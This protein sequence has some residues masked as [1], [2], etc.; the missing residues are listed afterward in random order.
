[1]Q[2][3]QLLFRHNPQTGIN[4]GEVDLNITGDKGT[5]YQ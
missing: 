2:I 3:I 5:A 1:M 4:D